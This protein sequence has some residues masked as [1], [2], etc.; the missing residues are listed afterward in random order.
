MRQAFAIIFDDHSGLGSSFD[1][2]DADVA[3]GA[4][5]SSA[6]PCLDQFDCILDDVNQRLT[7]EPRI[8]TNGH[9]M[10]WKNRLEGN[11]GMSSALQKHRLMHDLDQVLRFEDRRRHPSERREFVD[12]AADVA[13]VPDDGIG[14]DVK[15]SA[16]F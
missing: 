5:P 16:S 4:V 2:R 7:N 13:D 3:G 9:G 12:H 15:V 1:N 8:A 10:R 6:T 14:T 11:L